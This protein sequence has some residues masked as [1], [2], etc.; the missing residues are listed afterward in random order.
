MKKQTKTKVVLLDRDGVINK[1]RP[2][3][4][5]SVDELEIFAD[6]FKAFKLLKEAGYTVLIITNQ[7]GVGKGL[8]SVETL[9]LI[10]KELQSKIALKGGRIDKIYVCPHKNE[11]LCSCR[12]PKPG[13]ILKAQ[14]EWNFDPHKTWMVGDSLVDVKAAKNAGLR[15]ALV[16][17]GQKTQPVM[18]DS[19]V[20]VFKSLLDFV[21]FLLI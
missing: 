5:K 14:N 13:L 12:K 19:D 11:D 3:Y 17:S 20:P 9:D 1:E 6:S 2:D 10:N 4:V 18:T 21:R 7:A 15:P 8:I 16:K